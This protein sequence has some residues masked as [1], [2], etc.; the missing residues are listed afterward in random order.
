MSEPYYD[1]G[2]AQ[3]WHGDALTVLRELPD[4]S[5]HVVVTSPPYYALRDYGTARWEG[6]D[7]DCDHHEERGSTRG[8]PQSSLTGGQNMSGHKTQYRAVC[9][10]CGAIRVDQQIGLEET[11]AEY[12][13]KLVAVFAERARDLTDDVN[14]LL[15]GDPCN[16][17]FDLPGD[18]RDIC[19]RWMGWVDILGEDPDARSVTTVRRATG[20]TIMLCVLDALERQ[21]VRRV[22]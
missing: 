8:G 6:G 14:I 13:A 16:G 22:T 5:V 15:Y 18:C 17:I 10:K 1:D 4:E 21:T 7:P 2:Q 11:P 20:M 9:G 19:R 3:I 12:I